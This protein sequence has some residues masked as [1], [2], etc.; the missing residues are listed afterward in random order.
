MEGGRL[1]LVETDET[2]KVDQCSCEGHV[3]AFIAA[4]SSLVDRRKQLR[5][6]SKMLPIC[7]FLIVSR[8]RQEQHFKAQPLQYHDRF[9]G[10]I[11]IISNRLTMGRHESDCRVI[12]WIHIQGG[13]YPGRE[14]SYTGSCKTNKCTRSQPSVECIMQIDCGHS[15]HLMLLVSCRPPAAGSFQT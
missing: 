3:R 15:P 1:L 12:A 2:G 8:T 9:S 14:C 11:M 10:C 13:A 7:L 4:E 5:G 6:P